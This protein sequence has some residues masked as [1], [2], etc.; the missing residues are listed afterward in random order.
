LCGHIKK[1]EKKKKRRR[2]RRNVNS[3]IYDL[4]KTAAKQV[5]KFGLKRFI[6]I[7]CDSFVTTRSEALVL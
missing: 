4:I 5:M 1:K 6:V 2:S 3:V 7:Q